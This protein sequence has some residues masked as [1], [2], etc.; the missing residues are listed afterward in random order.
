M[1]IQRNQPSPE[2]QSVLSFVSPSVADLLFFETVDAKTVG[3]GGGKTVTAIS[4]ASQSST[5]G[6]VT[7]S[8][9]HEVGFLVQVTST[10]HG[11]VVGDVVTVM[12]APDGSNGLNPNGTLSFL[13]SL[14]TSFKSS[15]ETQDAIIPMGLC[16]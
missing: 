2:R 16:F 1:P 15:K 7:D 12:N 6:S 9:Y 10:A 14:I 8:D 11:F 13:A 4:S 3:A 5:A